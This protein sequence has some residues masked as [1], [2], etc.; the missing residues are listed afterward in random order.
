MHRR[1]GRRFEAPSD[2]YAWLRSQYYARGTN[3]STR[4]LE[5]R[6]AVTSLKCTYASG[7]ASGYAHATWQAIQT[8]PSSWYR[9]IVAVQRGNTNAL[10]KAREV[11]R[12]SG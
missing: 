11:L 1:S 4:E 3:P 12:H 6:Y 9:A 8:M 2:V 5:S 7:W 10:K